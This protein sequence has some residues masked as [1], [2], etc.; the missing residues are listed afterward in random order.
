MLCVANGIDL[1]EI[2]GSVDATSDLEF[3]IYHFLEKQTTVVY[4]LPTED[5]PTFGF[6]IKT[7]ELHKL[8]YISNA[9]EKSTALSIYKSKKGFRNNLKGAFLLI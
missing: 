2:K 1:T 4:V 6:E 8:I 9:S 5:D 7:D 3:Y